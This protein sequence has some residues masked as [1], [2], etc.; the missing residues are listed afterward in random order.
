MSFIAAVFAIPTREF[1]TNNG[2]PSLTFSYVAKYLFG[3]G[4]AISIPL[5]AVAFAV[6]N[7]GLLIK[8]SLGRLSG[9]RGKKEKE[10]KTRE[11]AVAAAL[12]DEDDRLRRKSRDTYRGRASYDDYGRDISPMKRVLNRTGRG[13]EEKSEPRVSLRISRDLERGDGMR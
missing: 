11:Q 1:S 7:L 2:T 12:E 13:W 3:V 9:W 6:D 5:I 4:L 8:R 10:R